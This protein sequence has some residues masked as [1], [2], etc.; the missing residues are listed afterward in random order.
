[1]IFSAAHD[2]FLSLAC[3]RAGI[4]LAWPLYYHGSGCTAT[5]A[6]RNPLGLDLATRNHRRQ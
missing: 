1:M 5:P 3:V 4:G 2:N 6:N